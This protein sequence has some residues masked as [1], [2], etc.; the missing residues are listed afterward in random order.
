MP[1]ASDLPN[2]NGA[3]AAPVFTYSPPTAMNPFRFLRAALS[4]GVLALLAS[5]AS[6]LEKRIE[7]NPDLFAKLSPSDQSLVRQGRLREGMTQEAV[8][9]AWG[10][11]DGVAEGVQKGVKTEQWTYL[12]SQPVYT[13]TFYGGWGWG[14]WGGWGGPGWRRGGGY[15]GSWDPY[16]GGYGSSVT[17]IPYRSASVSFRN[18]RVT[19]YLRGPQ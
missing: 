6:P 12:G 9:L 7:R 1:C 8:F 5:C 13:D 2:L 19:E 4:L 15:C 18:D 10:R 11:P 17:Y 3:T 16:W 14:G